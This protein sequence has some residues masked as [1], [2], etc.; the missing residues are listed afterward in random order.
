MSSWT[1]T[2]AG[3]TARGT[4]AAAAREGGE[5]ERETDGKDEK[6]EKITHEA[7]PLAD[8]RTEGFRLMSARS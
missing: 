5:K 4:A 6:A 1:L 3:S 2:A 7:K 8:E